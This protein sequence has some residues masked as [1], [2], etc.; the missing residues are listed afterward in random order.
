MNA[1]VHNT[2]RVLFASLLWTALA[3]PAA[4]QPYNGIDA[5]LEAYRSHEAQR[6]ARTG[7]QVELS[8][9]AKARYFY[10][11]WAFY[12]GPL[13]DDYWGVRPGSPWEYRYEEYA[14]QPLG[15]R[16][17]Q[18]GPNRWEYY[19]IYAEDEPAPPPALHHAIVPERADQRPEHPRAEP[20]ARRRLSGPREF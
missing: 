10:D 1:L 5:G 15:H 19:P 8:E 17:I 9:A 2:K 20:R 6:L 16:T 3:L 7:R 18:L 11:R 12:G 4:A 14:R 13:A